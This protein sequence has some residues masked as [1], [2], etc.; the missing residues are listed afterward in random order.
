[1]KHLRIFLFATLMAL[2][3]AAHAGPA[4]DVPCVPPYEGNPALREACMIPPLH[5]DYPPNAPLCGTDQYGEPLRYH[6][7]K[8][9][10]PGSYTGQCLVCTGINWTVHNG[11]HGQYGECR[12]SSINSS[13]YVWNATYTMPLESRSQ[14]SCAWMVYN[15]ASSACN[16]IGWKCGYNGRDCD[17]QAPPD[18]QPN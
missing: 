3:L 15:P 18:P 7:T 13:G 4:D 11:P 5:P 1:M 17:Y 2:G 8:G 9:C 12:V 6:P 14:C 10:I 16:R